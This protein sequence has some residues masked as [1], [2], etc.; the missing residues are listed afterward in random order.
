MAGLKRLADLIRSLGA[1]S[2]IQ[3][4]HSG[5][6][7]SA[8]RPWEGGGPLAEADVAARGEGPWEI[9][10]ALGRELL[11]NPNWPAQTAVGFDP[12]VGL[13]P[14]AGGL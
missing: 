11:W 8:Q 13:G 6:K 3:I 10:A 1:A 2:A 4:A 14:L 9:A 5:C 12:G 7:G